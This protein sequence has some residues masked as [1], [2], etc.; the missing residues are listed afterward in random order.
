MANEQ[1]ITCGDGITLRTTDD[2]TALCT[3]DCENTPPPCCDEENPSP[4]G[5]RW[6]VCFSRYRYR[7][8]RVASSAPYGVLTERVTEDMNGGPFAYQADVD[9][10]GCSTAVTDELPIIRVEEAFQVPGTVEV[11]PIDDT[12]RVEYLCR[13]LGVIC[14]ELAGV[15]CLP[16]SS[17]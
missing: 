3:G 4:C 15:A 2:G 13:Y 8:E 7:H 10:F 17:F 9:A 11:P 14:G 6:M 16:P 1:I 5:R 12:R